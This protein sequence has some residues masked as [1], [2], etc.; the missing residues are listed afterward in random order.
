MEHLSHHIILFGKHKHSADHSL[1]RLRWH[2]TRATSGTS[3]TWLTLLS[4]TL[5]LH[6]VTAAGL[7]LSTSRFVSICPYTDLCYNTHAIMPPYASASMM[8]QKRDNMGFQLAPSLIIFLVILGA[9][10]LVCCGFAVFR[11]YGG[12]AQDD[13]QHYNRSPEQDAYMREVRE[14]SWAKLP[15]LGVKGA[16]YPNQNAHAPMSPR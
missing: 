10:A 7:R 6:L 16:Y 13:M 3:A 4:R 11:F 14:R 2:L 12:D 5:V 1:D 8:L 9:G 15:K